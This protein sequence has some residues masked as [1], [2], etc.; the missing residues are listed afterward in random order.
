MVLLAVAA[1]TTIVVG[2]S[3]D[4]RPTT[5]R[6]GPRASAPSSP[7][8][9]IELAAAGRVP[10]TLVASIASSHGRILRVHEGV[11]M[12]I[13]AGLTAQAATALQHAPGV[14]YVMPD[15]NIR[16]I[17]D[18]TMRGVVA[19]RGAHLATRGAVSARGNPRNAHFFPLQWSMMQTQADSAWSISTQG[20]GVKV[21]ILDTGVDTAHQ[22]LKGLVDIPLCTSFAFA[23]SDTL[24]LNPL[25]FSHDVVG[26]GSFVSS[27]VAS[28]S[29][30]VAAVAPQAKLVMVRV[31]DDSGS[32]S[33]SAL[34]SGI[35]YAVDSG[36]DIINMSLGGYLPRTPAASWRSPT[37]ISAWSTTP[38]S[39]T[40]SW[41][42]RRGTSPSI[43]IR[44]RRRP[45]VTSTASIRQRGCAT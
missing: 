39:I 43:P 25:P 31:L 10:T 12:V 16:M 38:R 42:P 3:E 34:L 8:Y 7:R 2:C 32:G 18:P 26:H 23:S 5:S 41:S 45:A 4:G 28:N 40:S 21:F 11:G 13:V 29:I 35:L 1:C 24:M 17:T 15:L 14:R 19:L 33:S 36:A 44:R 27:I 22:D 30:G 20:S 9:I 37:S 6:L